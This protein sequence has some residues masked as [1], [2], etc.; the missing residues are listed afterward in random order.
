MYFKE[1]AELLPKMDANCINIT[2]TISEILHNIY[3]CTISY[4]YD[5]HEYEWYLKTEGTLPI[6]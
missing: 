5:M 2:V 1:N 4:M 3:I 6:Q